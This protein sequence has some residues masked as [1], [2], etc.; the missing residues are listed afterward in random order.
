M[1]EQ[2]VWFITGASRGFG[3][4]LVQQALARGDVVIA[5][6]RNGAREVQDTSG[7]LHALRLDVTDASQ[8]RACVE[9]A[10]SIQGRLDVVVN[11]A[12]Y[13]LFCAIEEASEEQLR[14]MF[15]VNFFGA[16]NVIKAVLPALR[17]RRSGHIVNFSSIGGLVTAPGTGL[18]SASKFALEGMSQSL[19]QEL[20]PLGIHV[21]I[22]EPG[23]FRTEFLSGASLETATARIA[24]YETSAHALIDRLKARNGR[25]PGD[26]IRAVQVIIEAINSPQPPQHLLLGSDTLQRLEARQQQFT[27]EIARWRAAT[28][29]TDLPT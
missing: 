6:S 12:G 3:R 18:Y 5:T 13:G 10:L 21:T 22:V 29:S 24:D 11:N 25:Q 14:R 26:P 16:W 8:V 23:S 27:D 19:A 4:E 2:K 1:S 28:L 9:R 17:A 20:A 15:E 7:R